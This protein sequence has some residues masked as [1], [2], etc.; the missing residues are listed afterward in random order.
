MGTT[1]EDSFAGRLRELI[2]SQSVRAVARDLEMGQTTIQKYLSGAM[3]GLEAFIV[4]AQHFEVSMDWLATGLGPKKVQRALY[5][6]MELEGGEELPEGFMLIPRLDVAASAGNGTLVELENTQ[7]VVA[8]RTDWLREK[9]INPGRTHVLA[10]KGD[11]MEPTIRDGDI[12][13]VDT[14]IDH[15]KDNAIYVVVFAG[16]TLVKR[17]Q[18]LRDGSVVIKSDNSAAFDDETVPSSEVPDLIVAG[19]VMWYGRSI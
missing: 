5:H 7:D 16:R 9:G 18:L 8:F 1:Q 11:S 10:A 12:L 15:V 19:R 14:S 3:P 13:L 6:R 2:G 4:I 17:L